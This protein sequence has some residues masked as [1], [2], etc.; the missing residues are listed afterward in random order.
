MSDLREIKMTDI[1]EEI[2]ADVE[3]LRTSCANDE[4][5]WS[6]LCNVMRA[7]AAQPASEQCCVCGERFDAREIEDGGGPNGC[8]LTG[9]RWVCSSDCFERAAHACRRARVEMRAEAERLRAFRGFFRDRCEVLFSNFGMEAVDLYNAS[10]PLGRA[11]IL[12]DRGGDK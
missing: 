9:G 5:A 12:A 6:A 4:S 2:R 3:T 8:E 11:A 10:G 1:P 7:L